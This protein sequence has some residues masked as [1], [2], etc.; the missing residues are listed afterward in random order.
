M[1]AVI[2][3]ITEQKLADE[4]LVRVYDREKK[5]RD[6]AEEAN[7]AKDF[8]LAF[9][10]HELRSPLNAILGW[11]K[12]LLSRPVDE[13]TRRSALET[14]EKSARSQAK[15]INDLVDSAR[16]A[17]GKISL[18]YRPTN[19][20]EI[21]KVSFISQKPAADIRKINLEFNSDTDDVTI[22]GDANRLQQV[23][24]NLISN[25]IKFT[26]EGG[27]IS[28]NLSKRDDFA[29]VT[30]SDNGRG[31][32]L[33]SLPNI[34]RQFSQV[35]PTQDLSK[36]G[37]GLGLSIVKILV[38][39]HGGTVSATSPGL[40]HG[41][42]FTVRLPLRTGEA[43]F[44]D[45]A[46]SVQPNESL[47]LNGLHILVVEDDN[48]SREVLQLFLEQTGASVES[49][50]SAKD[51]MS[52]FE[53]PANSLPDVMISDLAMPEEDGYSLIARIR[54]LPSEKGGKIPAI[55]LSAFATNESKQRAIECGFDYYSSKPFEP[56][57]LTSDILNVL[58]QKVQAKPFT[59]A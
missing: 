49:V 50:P 56:D 33:D 6:E 31:I 41:S 16:V 45:A 29:E 4:E 55:A 43:A 53:R 30:V 54:Q 25:S 57:M 42:T 7:R 13:D 8:F 14:I 24:V 39:K 21:V 23:F 40:G 32:S 58:R 10:S 51:A 18:E 36:G 20:H 44:H 38:G 3:K 26:D 52:V 2:R 46:E 1:T 15:L 9:V 28:V 11:S 48:D 5:A 47:A 35:Q 22:F 12:I 19:L 27:N 59:P 34:F 37:L 17:S